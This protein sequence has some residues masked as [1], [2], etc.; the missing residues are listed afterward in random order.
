MNENTAVYTEHDTQLLGKQML[1][2]NQAHWEH[3]CFVLCKAKSLFS[4]SNF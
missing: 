2:P 4:L 3:G 1:H